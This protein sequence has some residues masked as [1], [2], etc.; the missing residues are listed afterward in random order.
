MPP[1]AFLLISLSGRV[2]AKAAG[3]AQQPIVGID[4]FADRDTCGMAMK[5]A[6]SPLDNNGAFDATAMLETADSACPPAACLGLVYGSGFETQPELLR[7]LSEGRDLLGNSPKVLETVA[8]PVRFSNLLATLGIPHPATR[9]SRPADV[10][11]WLSKQ[12]GACGGT[13]VCLASAAPMDN[14]GR[15]FQQQVVGEEWSFLFLADGRHICP[16]GFN[17]PLS[18]PVEASGHWSYAGATRMNAGPAGMSDAVTDAVRVLA[19]KLGL[20]GLNGIDFIVTRTGWMLLELNPRPPATLELWDVPL[21]PCLF[22]RHIEA[23]KGWLPKRL[24]TPDGSMVVAVI[25]ARTRTSIHD[26]FAWPDWCADLPWAG[27]VIEAGEPV[28]TV[29]AEGPDAASTRYLA[30]GRRQEILERLERAP[31]PVAAW[32]ARAVSQTNLMHT[33]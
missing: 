18:T 21:L 12:A 24:P 11:G 25:Y 8:D 20:V 3:R 30:L 31:S 28:C 13:H 14:A 19:A 16:V 17:Q 10:E 2:L 4:A 5:W 23:C 27:T 9:M 33:A 7:A 1:K 29:R 26:D 32:N 6:H 15:Y 22:D